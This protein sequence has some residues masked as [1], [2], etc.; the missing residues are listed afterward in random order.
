LQDVCADGSIFVDRDGA[1]FEHVLEY[2]RDSVVAVAEPGSRPSINLLRALKREFGFYSIELYVEQPMESHQPEVAL[3]M[4]GQN[5]CIASAT[6][7]R[8]DTSSGHSSIAAA[9]STARCMFGA[10]TLAGVIYVTGGFSAVS[11]RTLSSVEKYTLSTDSWS[12]VAA[13]SSAV[14]Q[15]AAVA[16]GSAMYVLGGS[17]GGVCS[18]SVLKFDSTQGTWSQVEP[19]PAA[20]RLH[21]A[22]AI[23]NDIY[24]YGGRDPEG[25]NASVFKFDTETNIWSTLELMPLPCFNHS[26][27][28]LDG[29]QV[30]GAGDDGKGV[31]QF[32]TASGIWS[33]LGSTS[34]NKRGCATF[35]LR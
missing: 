5:A 21:A 35:L 17:Y 27:S 19:M 18:A 8:Y 7:E 13:L 31:L 32:S 4:G 22:C 29:D 26:V 20:R 10:C 25:R 1:H 15:H 12:T 9:M 3:M 34:N 33:T 2:M 14:F 24:I 23:G 28:V 30:F 16:V 6:T 11:M